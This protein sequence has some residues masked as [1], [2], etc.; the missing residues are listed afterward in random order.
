MSLRKL[1]EIKADATLPGARW[2]VRPD[3]L[4]RW[5]PRAAEADDPASISVYDRIGVD[6]W[7]GEG[8]T[9]KRIAAA[10]RSIGPKDVTVN[11]NSPGGDF[12][13]GVTIYNLLREHQGKVTV[14]VLGV[15][16]SAASLIAMAGDEIQISLA[17]FLM[18]HNAWAVAVGNRHDMLKAAETLEPFDAAMADVYAART[19]IERKQIVKAMDAETWIGGQSAI[20]EGWAD[21]LIADEPNEK[22]DDAQASGRRAIAMA[23]AAFARAGMSR[24]ER[25]ALLKDLTGGTPSAAAPAMPSAGDLAAATEAL[26]RLTKNIRTH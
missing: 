20:D 6:P 5:E 21:R 23:E 11:V 14:R 17:S 10:L 2:E 12:F 4:E 22:P 24:K 7:T 9:A 25:R 13:E 8:V 16:A 26:Q 3:A 15:A 19:G 18:V 1:P